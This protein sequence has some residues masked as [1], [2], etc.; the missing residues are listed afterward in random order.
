MNKSVDPCEDFYEFACGGWAVS[1]PVPPTEMSWGTFN[2]VRKE[3]NLR[4]RGN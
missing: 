3:L 1:N 4:I 2:V